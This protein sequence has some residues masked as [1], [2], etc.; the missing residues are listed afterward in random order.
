MPREQYSTCVEAPLPPPALRH[1]HQGTGFARSLRLISPAPFVVVRQKSFEKDRRLPH[2]GRLSDNI[3]RATAFLADESA[4]HSL[5]L[6]NP[7]CKRRM[8]PI[9]NRSNLAP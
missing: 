8:Y 5:S 7:P 6:R 3:R 4:L 9:I 1:L 2:G